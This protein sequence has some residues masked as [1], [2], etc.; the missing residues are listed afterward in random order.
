MYGL[1]TVLV[2][3]HIY[4]G[5][6]PL[7]ELMGSFHHSPLSL[8]FSHGIRAVTDSRDWAC[9]LPQL[10]SASSM[11]PLRVDLCAILVGIYWS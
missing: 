5:V 3:S 11:L 9:V 6:F 1:H 7:G 4:I 2:H 8:S 10:S